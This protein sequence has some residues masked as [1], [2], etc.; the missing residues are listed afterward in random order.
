MC[1]K[2]SVTVVRHLLTSMALVTDPWCCLCFLS[3]VQGWQLAAQRGRKQPAA[4]FKWHRGQLCH[5]LEMSAK[6][7]GISS[8]PP[9]LFSYQVWCSYQR[10]AHHS[11]SFAFI[12]IIISCFRKFRQRRKLS[13]GLVTTQ[14]A[15]IFLF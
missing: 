10:Q 6:E 7:H 3:H 4:C 2:R 15:D 9:C 5:V 12:V 11:P 1:A 14:D 13:C 8:Q